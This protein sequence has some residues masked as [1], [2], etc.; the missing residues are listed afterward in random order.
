MKAT[1]N[2][3][4]AELA[5][6]FVSNTLVGRFYRFGEALVEPVIAKYTGTGQLKAMTIPSLK[7]FVRRAFPDRPDSIIRTI[8]EDIIND[9]QLPLDEIQSL[10]STPTFR[11]DLSVITK[12]GFDPASG[13]YYSPDRSLQQFSFRTD[14]SEAQ[15]KESLAVLMELLTD[16]PFRNKTEKLS[17]LAA[18]LTLFLRNAIGGTVPVLALDGNGQSVG[19][20]LL[21]SMLS[22]IAYGQDA[23]TIS[24]P[25]SKDEWA[26]K[27][28]SILLNCTPFQVI[29]NVVGDF[30]SETFSS[31][32]TSTRRGIR[33]KGF[34][35]EVD[36]PVSTVWVLNGNDLSV[37]SDLS[38]RMIMC[39]LAHEDPGAREQ[40]TFHIQRKYGCS[41]E[42]LLKDHRAKYLQSCLDIICGWVNEGAPKR[43]KLILAKYGRW[44]S[45]IGG[46]MD[47]IMPEAKFLADHKKETVAVDSEREGTILFLRKLMIEFPKCSTDA[48]GVSQICS[49]VF[50]DFGGKSTLRDFVPDGLLG[51]GGSS[52]A[53]KLGKWMKSVATRRW[54]TIELIPEEDKHGGVWKYRIGENIKTPSVSANSTVG[55]ETETAA[56]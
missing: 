44:E 54:G 36:V 16:F 14:A 28:D 17:Y 43:Q 11:E 22:L 19:K 47:W 1:S 25:K 26:S 53:K 5:D 29:D 8:A 45:I 2:A 48:I 46:I 38:Q 23:A 31:I 10:V 30:S 56:A 13:L 40:D 37:D 32:L 12:P 55:L 39:H 9:S 49:K 51:T 33:I 21:S 52:F 4:I 7:W 27:L 35:K 20:G 42:V 6:T 24:A 41:I 3:P 15:A 18:L 34:S 50:P